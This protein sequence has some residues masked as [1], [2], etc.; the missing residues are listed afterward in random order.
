MSIGFSIKTLLVMSLALTA[1]ACV[2]PPKKLTPAETAAVNAKTM[3]YYDDNNFVYSRGQR[4]TWSKL[5]SPSQTAIGLGF[6]RRGAYNMKDIQA[7]TTEYMR[8]GSGYEGHRAT[9]VLND[10]TKMQG[11]SADLR[12]WFCD[13]N[14][15]CT[16]SMSL[17]YR[18]SGENPFARQV[19]SVNSDKLR[20]VPPEEEPRKYYE[21]NALAELTTKGDIKVNV[22]NPRQTLDFH[23]QLARLDQSWI[24]AAPAR[25]ARAAESSRKYAAD[26]AAKVSRFKGARVGT[27]IM[28]PTT[29]AFRG[30]INNESWVEC[31]GFGRASVGEMMVYGWT[32]ASAIEAPGDPIWSSKGFIAYNITFQ[33]STMP[34]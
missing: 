12:W 14:Q 26:Q 31:P 18:H 20:T 30:A 4:T 3:R 33:K 9:I 19:W 21:D 6:D 29:G 28:C 13:R 11:D 24:D 34:K 27:L 25:A 7:Y 22:F 5:N 17:Y 32:M 10:G 16:T 23:N 8:R 1:T 2:M 15:G